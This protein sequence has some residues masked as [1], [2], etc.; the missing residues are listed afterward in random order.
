[1]RS[2]RS[3]R[4]RVSG[5]YCTESAALFLYAFP[6]TTTGMRRGP[7][8]VLKPKGPQTAYRAPTGLPPLLNFYYVLNGAGDMPVGASAR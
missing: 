3:R 8:A 1:M 7:G 4:K 6:A 2:P 5:E